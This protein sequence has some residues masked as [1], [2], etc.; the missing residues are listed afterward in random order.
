MDQSIVSQR[1]A[2]FHKKHGGE[3]YTDDT[4]FY[5]PDGAY[6]DVDRLG[7]LAEPPD[8][9]TPEGEYKRARF[10]LKFHKLKLSK[11][12]EAFDSLNTRLA[13]LASADMLA[14]EQLS[15]LQKEVIQQQAEVRAAEEQLA[16]TET[17]RMIKMQKEGR[18][19]ESRR[20]QEFHQLRRSIRI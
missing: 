9:H 12:V 4:Y 13:H 18:E 15:K 20:L 8:K 14:L 5:Y 7:L 17:G 3:C 11:K 19:A 16:Q 1:I 6:R 2:D 10:I